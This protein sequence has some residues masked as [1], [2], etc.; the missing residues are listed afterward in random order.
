M[1]NLKNI[2]TNLTF[3][4][5]LF[6]VCNVSGQQRKTSIDVSN[7]KYV[8]DP[9]SVAEKH[10]EGLEYI[11]SKLKKC[12]TN[13]ENSAYLYLAEKSK[14]FVLSV[15]LDEKYQELIPAKMTKNTIDHFEQKVILEFSSEF[16]S[17]Y[18]NMK[19]ILFMRNSS[20]L[21]IESL[22]NYSIN[23]EIE[24]KWELSILETFRQVSIS[25]ISYWNE[26][27]DNWKKNVN[28][29]AAK[30]DD[31]NWNIIG[32]ADAAGA[33]STAA[34]LWAS[35]TGV[36]MVAAGGPGGAVGVG[37][38]IAAGGIGSSASAFVAQSI[39]GGWF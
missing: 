25:S 36:A 27:G 31:F 10:N 2:I 22:N 5:A 21:V 32:F 20:S 38:V 15:D 30:S 3:V 4:F 9:F 11:Y 37:L 8:F 7:D 19:K 34:G 29:Y 12:P 1:K 39:F 14:D 33:V 24:D 17:D 23:E 35:G 28:G 6:M 16:Q 18:F 26:N 13:E